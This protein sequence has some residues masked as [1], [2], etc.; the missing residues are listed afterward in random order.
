MS[1][2][3]L[4]IAGF[5]SCIVTEGDEVPAEQE[6]VITMN[7]PDAPEIVYE[8]RH[9]S[10]ENGIPA[11][12]AFDKLDFFVF[13]NA[14]VFELHKDVTI[15]PSDNTSADPMWE[16]TT[17]AMR[18]TFTTGQKQ[19]YVIANWSGSATEMPS[20]SGIQSIGALQ[21]QLRTHTNVTPTNGPVMTGHIAHTFAGGDRVEINLTRQVARVTLYPMISES[22]ELLGGKVTIEGVKFV[23]MAQQSYLLPRTN[24]GP[25]TSVWS[26]TAYTGTSVGPITATTTAAATIYNVP[27]YIPE[28]F[29]DA[30]THT[31]MVI[32]AKYNGVNSYY[33]IPINAQSGAEP[34]LYAVERNHSY[35]YYVTIQGI[36]AAS[37]P[38]PSRLPDAGDPGVANITYEL[39]KQ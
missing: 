13:S 31:A 21:S 4:I 28:Y 34:A 20:I 6:F 14:G 23:N 27:M 9:G 7:V 18:L 32:Y 15:N 26:Q 10:S 25:S 12:S 24:T 35:K 16:P 5:S 3:A 1:A 37:Q 29:G 17:R 8:T 38:A 2:F 30:A 22:V 36:G 39:I 33:T 19:I 11:E